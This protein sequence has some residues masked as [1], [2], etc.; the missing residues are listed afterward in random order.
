MLGASSLAATR[1]RTGPVGR[2]RATRREVVS[3]C[4]SSDG[5]GGWSS[6]PTVFASSSTFASDGFLSSISKSLG[7]SFALELANEGGSFALE[8][9][10]EDGSSGSELGGGG[11]SLAL[12][13]GSG[14][15]SLDL[16]M[17]SGDGSLVPELGKGGSLS[18]CEGGNAGGSCPVFLPVVIAGGAGPSPPP[19]LLGSGRLGSSL[20]SA[21][22][23]PGFFF[24]WSRAINPSY[25]AARMRPF[26]PRSAPIAYGQ[27]GIPR[28]QGSPGGELTKHCRANCYSTRPS[29]VWPEFGAKERFP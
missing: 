25:E 24:F 16:A 27:K 10:N 23:A 17:G 3:G 19:F 8:L 15:G 18:V 5:F 14:G 9:A 26:V 12:D 4:E 20:P 11:G 28:D 13:L 21:L 6:T 7:G 22:S 1:W 29:M 2:R